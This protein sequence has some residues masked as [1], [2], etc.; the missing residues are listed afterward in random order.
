MGNLSS[1]I[2]GLPLPSP[3]NEP[4]ITKTTNLIV[5]TVSDWG[6]YGLLA[7]LS[8]LYG[9]NLLPNFESEQNLLEK[10]VKYG[11]VDGVST[12]NEYTVDGLTIKEH[13]RILLQL[14]EYVETKILAGEK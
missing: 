9:Q 13:N 6:G 5:S 12:L 2:P 11:A 3:I 8:I 10:C 4:C 7:A 14:R 1:L